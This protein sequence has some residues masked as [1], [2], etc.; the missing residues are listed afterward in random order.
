MEMLSK[1]MGPRTML[2]T[3]SKPMVWGRSM[4]IIMFGRVF[5][6]YKKKI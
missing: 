4:R 6:S 2:R 3:A 1:V 5:H